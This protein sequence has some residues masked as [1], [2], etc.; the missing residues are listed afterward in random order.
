MKGSDPRTGRKD[1]S[2]CTKQSPSLIKPEEAEDAFS[3]MC[4]SILLLQPGAVWT[5]RAIKRQSKIHQDK[6]FYQAPKGVSAGTHVKAEKRK[7]AVNSRNLAHGPGA[8]HSGYLLFHKTAYSWG[9]GLLWCGLRAWSHFINCTSS[10][11]V[12]SSPMPS[13]ASC[14]QNLFVAAPD[15]FSPD[16]G[17]PTTSVFN[18]FAREKSC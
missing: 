14:S 2:S 4:D 6:S 9:L 5:G 10:G 11:R 12:T 16:E 17:W 8:K 7:W 18:L 15:T 13:V 3:S 1:Q